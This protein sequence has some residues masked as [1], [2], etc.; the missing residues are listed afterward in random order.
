MPPSADQ[1][2]VEF[3]RHTLSNGAVLLIA[4]MEGTSLTAVNLL[5]RTG[6]RDED[7]AMTGLA[8]LMEHLMFSGTPSFPAFDPPLAGVGAINNA[9][10][11]QDFTNYHI[12]LPADHLALALE[13]EADRMVNLSLNDRSVSLQKDVVTEEFRQR[14]L[15]QPYGDLHHLLSS[16]A[17]EKH[18]YRWP[19]IGMD[20]SHV[21]RATTNDV[22]SFYRK[23]YH[24]G[25]A[26]LAV[27]G[28]VD[29]AEVLRLTERFFGDIPAV[30]DIRPPY[31]QE[32]TT[33]RHRS[34]TVQRNVPA[35]CLLV[36]FPVPGSH[37]R[38]FT[39]LG[40]LADILGQ[41][42]ISR[43][44]SELVRE[45]K[46][47]SRISAGLTATADPGLFTITGV[48]H[49]EINSHKGVE[50]ID[51]VIT[52]FAASGPTQEEMLAVVNGMIT[53]IL[54]KRFNPANLAMELAG[55]EFEGDV[56]GVN[57]LI[58]K[59]LEVTPE[60]LKAL[61]SHYLHPENRIEIHYLRD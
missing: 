3:Q 48:L 41:G 45:K 20:P 6:S 40:F 54:Y 14:Y 10:T 16:A 13:M 7:P 35:P 19:V 37:H 56:S 30:T 32:S 46:L 49:N 47:F 17:W 12:V 28:D 44:H 21:E 61:A 15:N 36:A 38:E 51:R 42:I 11:N 24:P 43:L 5:Y 53:Q 8:H 33:G 52:H 29:P 31:P 55:A 23:H 27:A 50:E 58:N 34:L 2:S 9:F 1:L 59:A 57:K 39:A 60:I 25:N 4:P 18:P 22:V 26:I